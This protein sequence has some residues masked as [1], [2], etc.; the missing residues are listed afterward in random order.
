MSDSVGACSPHFLWSLVRALRLDLEMG[1]SELFVGEHE[2]LKKW[3]MSYSEPG[4]LS[5]PLPTSARPRPRLP[6]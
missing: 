1:V 3:M 2:T 5:L 6:A 4:T